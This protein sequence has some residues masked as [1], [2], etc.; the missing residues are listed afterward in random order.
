MFAQA[1]SLRSLLQELEGLL[2]NYSPLM[3][4]ST[5]RALDKVIKY[6]AVFAEVRSPIMETSKTLI[7]FSSIQ[8]QKLPSVLPK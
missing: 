8:S 4:T 3:N 1:E 7:P 2:D 6:G 5:E